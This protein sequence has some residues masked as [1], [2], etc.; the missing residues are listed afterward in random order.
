M[1]IGCFLKS[2][3]ILHSSLIYQDFQHR[4]QIRA[5]LRL[6]GGDGVLTCRVPPELSK[7]PRDMIPIDATDD[8]SDGTVESFDHPPLATRSS[9]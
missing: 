3:A 2:P 6:V 9:K 8:R 5:L 1:S 7:V 4:H